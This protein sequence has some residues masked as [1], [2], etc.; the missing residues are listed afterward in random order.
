MEYILT[1]TEMA[2]CDTRTSE[3]IGIPSL[4]LMER[5]ALSVADGADDYLK[6]YRGGKGIILAAAG[7]GNNGADALAA[8]RI[9]LDRG[10]DVRFCRLS[11]E[12]SPDSSFAVQERIL[13]SYGAE[14]PTVTDSILQ[15][16]RLPPP[17]DR[18]YL[19]PDLSD[20]SLTAFSTGA[21]GAGR[22]PGRTVRDRTL[23]GPVRGSS[24][25]CPYCQSFP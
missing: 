21:A 24:G 17:A 22:Y 18:P 25:Y 9:L 5:A 7:R 11:G 13:A 12:I 15:G 19:C 6:K 4:V 3:V 8:G 16:L 23:T 14:V 2:E 1:G 20:T 10:Y